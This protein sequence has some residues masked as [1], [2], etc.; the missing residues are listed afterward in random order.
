M[1]KEIKFKITENV[2]LWLEIIIQDRFGID[3][4]IK[5]TKS[6]FY[7]RHQGFRS[8]ILIK[9]DETLFRQ[10]SESLPYSYWESDSEGWKSKIETGIPA[11]GY[12][13]LENPLIKK[14]D[15]NYIINYD[16]LSMAYW[17]LSRIE[18]VNSIDLDFHGRFSAKLSHAF[19]YKY[20][21][22]PIVDEWLEI[23]GKVIRLIWPS[24]SLKENSF[25]LVVTCDID[26][27][28]AYYG[29]FKQV[30]KNMIF[31]L[32]NAGSS[33]LFIERFLDILLFVLGK[34]S[35][36]PYRVG[37][38]KIMDINEKFGNKVTFYLIP[39]NT[40]SIYDPNM[41]I[42]DKRIMNIVREVNSRGHRLGIHPGYSSLK[43]KKTFLN[44]VNVFKKTL[45]QNNINISSIYGRQHYLRWKH[46]NTANL[47]SDCKINFDSSLG[48]HD[49]PGFRCGTCFEYA[50]FDPKSDKILDV[51][52]S[53]L[54]FMDTSVFSKD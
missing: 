15:I 4:T 21:D 39:E 8:C 3:L 12:S 54:I 29:N 14:N 24:V 43:N 28:Y 52:E 34:K 5:K 23:L 10:P 32:A 49:Y 30:I 42:Y 11:P 20:L 47:Y 36:D 33:K 48:Y 9:N 45:S 2:I 16:I 1:E 51:I 53:P 27:P 6:F 25:S 18:E 22:R 46:P 17:M 40:S 31:Q 41:P 35:R 19:R 44:S 26:H 37:I 38:K 50:L 7:L 13:K